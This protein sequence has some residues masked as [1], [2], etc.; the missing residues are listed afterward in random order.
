MGLDDRSGGINLPGLAAAALI[1]A[2]F[3]YFLIGDRFGLRDPPPRSGVRV[4][5]ARVIDPPPN[6]LE[7]GP[8]K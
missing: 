1:V 3:A 8:R 2:V 6:D 4:E 7:P 5:A